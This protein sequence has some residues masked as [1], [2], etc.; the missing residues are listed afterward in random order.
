M[1]TREIFSILGDIMQQAFFS[2]VESR[3][4]KQGNHSIKPLF[5]AISALHYSNPSAFFYDMFINDSSLNEVLKMRGVD[6]ITEVIYLATH[7]SEDGQ[8]GTDSNNAVTRVKFRNNLK[9][10]NSQGQIKGLYLGTC[11]TGK[12]DIVKF[13]LDPSCGT[14]LQWIIGYEKSVEWIDGS[15]IDMI[16]FS[17]LS[18]EYIKNKSRKKKKTSVEM[19]HIAVTEVL[20]LVSSAHQNFGFNFYRVENG[21]IV[22]LFN[23]EF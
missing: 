11:F 12:P 18:D 16:F 10:A 15:A 14:N 23:S 7:G 21:K 13:I 2:V 4:W 3:W 9:D 19:A 8:I 17:K 22:S 6:N 5:E 20:K 1:I